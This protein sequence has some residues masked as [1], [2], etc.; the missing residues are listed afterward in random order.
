MKAS[1]FRVTG[2]NGYDKTFKTDKNG[3]ILIDGLRIGK[4]VV[5]EVNDDAA[6]GYI[7]PD[8]EVVKIEYGKTASVKMHNEK[9]HVPQ[10]GDDS[11]PGSLWL[12]IGGISAAGIAACVTALVRKSKKH[13]KEAA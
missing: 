6:A 1:H 8:D 11:A 5:S 9:I 4:Y 2:E 3:V 13:N 12:M 10:T 7:L